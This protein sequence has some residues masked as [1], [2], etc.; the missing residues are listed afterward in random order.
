MVA[1]HGGRRSYPPI[2]VNRREGGAMCQHEFAAIGRM[3][4][5]QTCRRYAHLV[6]NAPPYEWAPLI[7]F[8]ISYV[9]AD[10]ADPEEYDPRSYRPAKKA[11]NKEEMRKSQSRPAV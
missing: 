1:R 7:P 3:G 9:Y 5:F 4:E 2:N 11:A 6:P 8:D 10:R